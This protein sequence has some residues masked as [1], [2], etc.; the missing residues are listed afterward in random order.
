MNDDY[1]YQIGQIAVPS[2]FTKKRVHMYTTKD[3]RVKPR[4]EC[5]YLAVVEGMNGNG[6]RFQA[7]AQLVNLSATGLF[8]LVHR[9]LT[10]GSRITVTIHLTDPS[11]NPDAP[12]LATN[13][14]VVRTEPGLAGACG[15]AIKFQNYRFL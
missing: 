10:Y 4:I 5:D 14:I 13:G 12:R 2:I 1:T 9:D 3:R 6:Y 11:L 15:I 7:N 8:M